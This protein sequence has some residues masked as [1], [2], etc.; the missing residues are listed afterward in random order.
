VLTDRITAMDIPA[1]IGRRTVEPPG[2]HHKPFGL[3]QHPPAVRAMSMSKG[4]RPQRVECTSRDEAG[5]LAT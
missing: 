1:A 2:P 3:G 4:S 5:R